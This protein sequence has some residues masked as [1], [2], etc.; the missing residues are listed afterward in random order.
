VQLRWKDKPIIPGA[1]GRQR[2]PTRLPSLPHPSNSTRAM[3][4]LRKVPAMNRGVAVR[5]IL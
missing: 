5:G 2:Q 4:S 1:G 3:Q